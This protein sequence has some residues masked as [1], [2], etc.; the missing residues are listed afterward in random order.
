MMINYHFI[1]MNKMSDPV[2][3]I[4]NYLHDLRQSKPTVL[5]QVSHPPKGSLSAPKITEEVLPPINTDIQLGK[6]LP[7]Y[8]I[9]QHPIVHGL[10]ASRAPLPET[11]DWRHE[12]PRDS[13]EIK[14]KKKILTKPNN[15]ALCG[16]CWAFA[17]AELISD[18]FV[19]QGIVGFN[20]E[21]SVTYNLVCYPQ[22]QCK[23]G[24]P[25]LL[26]KDIAHKG[27]A[28]NH[29]IDYSWC[30]DNPACSG[31]GVKHMSEHTNLNTLIPKNCGCYYPDDHYLYRITDAQHLVAKNDGDTSKVVETVKYHILSY[32]PVGGAYIV[33]SNF[34]PGKY[35]KS[36]GVYLEDVDYTSPKEYYLKT[37]AKPI[38]GHLVAVM[39]W[40]VAKNVRHKNKQK[41]D[42]HGD[43]PYWYC[44]NS[45][46]PTWGSDGGY[47]K[48]A[49]YPF[50]KI[51]QFERSVIV[52]TKGG[53]LTNG[54]MVTI[55]AK[56]VVPGKF[57]EVPKHGKLLQS[58]DYYQEDPKPTK[59]IPDSGD[60]GIA[61]LS[62]GQNKWLWIGIALGVLVIFLLFLAY[63]L[64]W[65]KKIK[66]P[67]LVWR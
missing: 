54:G 12:Y 10:S 17:S 22:G 4:P 56:D 62:S 14:L 63:R 15:Q 2:L 53:S 40:G 26:M 46:K 52:R 11:W 20:P 32:G 5:R 58:D 23:G 31:E 29:C 41:Q 25:A 8:D 28:S 60:D 55:K 49:M 30:L 33:M 19:V 47:F 27:I 34:P 35:E 13:H 43:V 24:N 3:H 51:S 1:P 48:I 66:L 6:Y 64:K 16:S 65:I 57:A 59:G 37:P 21:L 9:R 45:W 38:G 50:N 18:N 36:G 39:G 67:R 42:V 7:Q 44:R 61:S